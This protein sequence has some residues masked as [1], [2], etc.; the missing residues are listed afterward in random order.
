MQANKD[1]RH[2][3]L[4]RNEARSI[5][6][7]PRD[8]DSL[9][10]HVGDARLVLLGEATHGTH[11]FYR[12]RA[13]ITRRLITEKGFSAVAVEADWPDAYRINRYIRGMRGADR[14]A[15]DALSGFVRFPAWM[16]NNREMF[17]LVE[18]LHHYNRAVDSVRRQ[19]G[20]Y[21]LDLYS[22][23]RS[24]EAVIAYLQAV[25]PEAARRAHYRY[26]CFEHF[27]EDPQVYGYTTSLGLGSGCEDDV[28]G[29]LVELQQKQAQY[30]AKNGQASVDDYFNALQNA[31]VIRDSEQYYRAMFRGR[32]V[33][34]NL[35]DT[36]MAQ[37]LDHL[38][39]YLEEKNQHRAR[40]VIWAHN[41]HIGDARAT[42]LG[43]RGEI[44]L[45]QLVRQKYGDGAMLI[46]FST[47]KGRVTAASNWDAPEE[48]KQV[49]RALPDSYEALLHECGV[50]GFYLPLRHGSPDLVRLFNE[51]RLERAIGVIYHPQT[52]RI[53]HYFYARMGQQFDGVIHLDE[54]R[55]V[56]PIMPSERW[57]TGELPESYPSGF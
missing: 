12:E 13:R 18:W 19:V 35:R 33:S 21:G 28:V 23:F 47:Y 25:D 17:E 51:P 34:W 46:G 43:E 44:N 45:G 52:E 48:Q 8:Y 22:L 2:V 57:E 30:A 6:G 20:F 53:S 4:V 49:T 39:D 38:L 26:S 29:Q 56:K 36:H 7:T 24:I 40:V 50:P 27:S 5:T 31:R 3:V 42:K 10:A 16:W 54:T 37:T 15:L 41:S 11:E 14:T 55:P 1:F 32:D 9:M